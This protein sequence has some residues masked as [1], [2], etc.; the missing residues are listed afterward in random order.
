MFPSTWKPLGQTHPSFLSTREWN[1]WKVKSINLVVTI[2][3]TF[4]ES[5]S[6][7]CGDQNPIDPQA[8]VEREEDLRVH[9]ETRI[10]KPRNFH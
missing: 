10:V 8:L 1:A 6:K 9:L 3:R 2:R 4:L 5:V 7:I